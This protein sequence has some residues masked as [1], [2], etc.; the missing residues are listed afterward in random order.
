MQ[1]NKL[2]SETQYF[3]IYF[4]II[5][6]IMLLVPTSLIPDLPPDLEYELQ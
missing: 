5:T 6:S 3:F 1:A 2:K 4:Y